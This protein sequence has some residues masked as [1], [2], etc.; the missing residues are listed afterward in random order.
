MGRCP[1]AKHRPPTS[2][3]STSRSRSRRPGRRASPGSGTRC[4]TASRRRGSPARCAPCGASTRRTASTACR[5]AWPDPDDRHVAEFCENGA[6]AVAWEADRK[7]VEPDFWPTYT[8]SRPGRAQRVLARPAGPARRAGLQAGRQRPLR[9]DQLGRGASTSS[10]DELQGARVTR[11]GDLL[12]VAAARATRRRSSTSCSCARSAP[13][14]CPTA[15]TCATSRPSIAL[16]ETIG[17]GKATVTYDDFAQAELIIIMGQNPGTNHP[18]MLTRARGGEAQR[19]EDRRD[20]PAARGRAHAVQEPADAPSGLAGKGTELADLYLPIRLGG[21]MA[22]LQAVSK[23]VLAAED[24]HPGRCS[25]STS[26]TPSTL[27]LDAFEEHLAGLDEADVLRGHRPDH[28]ADRRAR[29]PCT[30][31]SRAHDRLLG[32]GP[33][34]APRSGRHDPRDRQPAAAARQHRQARRRRSPDPWAQ[35]RPG[36][37]DDGHLGEAADRTSS[38]RWRTSSASRCLASTGMTSSMRSGR[39]RTARSRS[40]SRSAATSSSAVSDTDVTVDALRRT[41]LTVQVSTKLNRSHVVTGAQALIL[42]TLGRTE[43]DLQAQRCA[44]RHA[45]RTPCARCTRSVGADPAAR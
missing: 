23:R 2:P 20:Q 17:I 32:D 10:R 3:T 45:S 38:T 43:I 28:R 25:T 44:V 16:A 39:C 13:T 7:H 1:S 37:P 36:R 35:Q 33:D 9:A 24:R 41:R 40:S 34:A 12:H 21:D 27:G 22:L 19:R 11:R 15:R 4:S 8:V 26:S 6:K 14:T 31:A 5:C 18:R 29:R 30:S 42:P